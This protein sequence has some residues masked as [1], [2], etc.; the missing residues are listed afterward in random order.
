MCVVAP[1]PA[2]GFGGELGKLY[3][4]NSF[5]PVGLVPFSPKRMPTA[6]YLLRRALANKKQ[7]TLSSVSSVV[8]QASPLCVVRPMDFKFAVQ[9]EASHHKGDGPAQ[10]VFAICA[11]VENCHGSGGLVSLPVG[12]LLAS[13]GTVAAVAA[14]RHILAVADGAAEFVFRCLPFEPALGDGTAL[15]IARDW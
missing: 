8:A 12:L 5:Q 3:A 7:G 10:P 6:S 9:P 1:E 15:R 2:P 14:A 4:G 13:A 11:F